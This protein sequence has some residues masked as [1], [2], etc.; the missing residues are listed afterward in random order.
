MKILLTNDDGIHADGIYRLKQVLDN[1]AEVIVVAPDT[2]RSAVGH[3]ITISDPLRVTEVEKDGKF[4]GYAVNGMPADCVKIGISALLKEKPDMV[5]SGINQ[6]PNTATNIIYS[7]TVS[8]AAEG[9]IM[10]IPSLALSLASFTVREFDYACKLA[11]QLVQKIYEHGLPEGTLLNV[12]VPALKEDHIE[13]IVITRQGK[14]RYEEFFDKRIDPFKRTYYWLSGK[15]MML[16][17]ENDID[18]VVVLQNKV[19]ITPICYDLTNLEM[20][21][22]LKSWKIEK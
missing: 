20:L 4:F 19:S 1:I 14:G 15:R 6:G 22:K 16:D 5:V 3:A 13:G 18:D 21:E 2:E 7:G 12:N 8:A 17:S 10:G 11:K 9:V